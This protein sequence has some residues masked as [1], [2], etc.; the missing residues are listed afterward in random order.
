MQYFLFVKEYK[1]IKNSNR[2]K[3]R[4]NSENKIKKCGLYQHV[5]I[6]NKIHMVHRLVAEAFIENIENK[7][8][9]NHMDG[10]RSNN[11]VLN[12]EWC[13]A[14]ENSDHAKQCSVIIET[15]KDTSYQE[16][17]EESS[18]IIKNYNNGLSSTEIASIFSEKFR[19][20][21]HEMVRVILNKKNLI[22][23]KPLRKD[24]AS[25]THIGVRKTLDGK[26]IFNGKTY[27]TITETL[28]AK[29]LFIKNK[30][31]NYS[32]IINSWNN[33][34]KEYSIKEF[35][36][37]VSSK[38]LQQKD[39]TEKQKARTENEKFYEE[40]KNLNKDGYPNSIIALKLNINEK[41]VKQTVRL[42]DE[43]NDP[44]LLTSLY[45]TIVSINTGIKTTS[46]NTY[47]FR[48][49]KDFNGNKRKK[50]EEARGDKVKIL[51]EKTLSYPFLNNL[52]K[53]TYNV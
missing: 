53:E 37:K 21:S 16:T 36:E 12:L 23:R 11:N 27:N 28:I 47:V 4:Y 42:L 33:I 14:K 35:D 15:T 6:N 20:I 34:Y 17:E 24:I 32:E 49:G 48:F 52:I 2:G 51:L 5:S 30:Y 19:S 41:K 9:V 3:Q 44:H 22:R 43:K 38:K 26:F 40:I 46:S 18:F 50:I 13:T 25:E 10:V 8:Y 29:D 7:P 31:S 1:Y 45:K 39:T